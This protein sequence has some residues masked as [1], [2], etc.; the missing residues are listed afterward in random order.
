MSIVDVASGL[1]LKRWTVLLG[2]AVLA[3]VLSACASRPSF[4]SSPL[5]PPETPGSAEELPLL[6][7]DLIK[8]T[9]FPTTQTVDGVYR[10]VAE[11]R[12]RVDVVDHPQLSRE[13]VLVLPD[14]SVSLPEAGQV[15][16]AGLTIAELEAQLVARLKASF[17]RNPR[18]TVS[19]EEGDARARSLVT[20]R[21]DSGNTELNVFQ[22]ADSG[23][24]SLPFIKPV[25]A[26]RPLDQVRTEIV[27]EYAQVFGAKIVVTVNLRQRSA[28]YVHVL[29][30]VTRP[31]NVEYR[32][33]F[34]PLMAI[35]T[36]GGF[37]P[38]AEQS[39][40]V[41]VRYGAD[42][43]DAQWMLDI[44]KGLVHADQSEASIALRPGDVLF[45]PK[46]GVSLAN[47]AIDQYV[48]RMIPLPANIGVGVTVR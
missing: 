42:G 7:G 27:S 33:P 31:G 11:D 5:P 22:V 18:V 43:K 1:S 23:L 19:V 12:L 46:T 44:E 26:R 8:V 15:K 41:L 25:D 20:Q 24:L 38:T 21:A 14:G 4:V 32:A 6:P 3:C 40:V 39:K 30:E 9:Y 37:L 36:A 47:D 48:R 35:G 13:H 17:I 29:G 2:G 45:V 34:N 28:R 16:A 10:I